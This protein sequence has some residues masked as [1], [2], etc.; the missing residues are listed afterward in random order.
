MKPSRVPTAVGAVSLLAGT[1]AVAPSAALAAASP[2]GTSGSAGL[3]SCRYTSVGTDT[4]TVP[5]GV[6][7]VTF[8]LLGAQGGSYPGTAPGGLGGQVIATLSV[9]PGQVFQVNVGGPGSADLAPGGINN[10]SGGGGSSDVRAGSFGLADRVLVAGGGGGGSSYVIPSALSATITAGANYGDGSV[11]AAWQW[12]TTLTVRPDV[13]NVTGVLSGPGGPLAGQT[14]T[15]TSG[16][17]S[18]CQAVTDSSGTA[19]CNVPL[20]GVAQVLLYGFTGSYAGDANYQSSTG[21]YSFLR[22]GG[23]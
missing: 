8:S 11:T 10:G 7:S 18:L 12:P 9:S 19:T 14:I 23:G 16:S 1:L 3:S 21:T 4:F 6:T 17:T 22:L 2:C 15:F 5:A 13:L 20:A